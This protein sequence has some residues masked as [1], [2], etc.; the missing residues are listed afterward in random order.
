MKKSV[1]KRVYL[2]ILTAVSLFFGIAGLLVMKWVWPQHYFSA[3]PLIPAYFFV[4]GFVYIYSFEHV[5]RNIQ[6]K[7]LLLFVSIRMMKLMTS[8]VVLIFYGIFGG[9]KV[10]EF[11]F[12]FILFYLIFL[13]FEVLFFY[14]FER[15]VERREKIEKLEKN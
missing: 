5:F 9:S 12:T 14:H 3:Y 13:V 10:K 15:S 6:Q 7:T 8:I 4:Y 2:T 1:E 11:M